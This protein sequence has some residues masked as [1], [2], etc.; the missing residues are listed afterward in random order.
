MPTQQ[1]T[2]Q[3]LLTSHCQACSRPPNVLV[4]VNL[5]CVLTL[6]RCTPACCLQTSSLQPALQLTLPT[7]CSGQRGF[8]A[9][10]CRCQTLQPN[11]S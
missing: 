4:R 3:Q 2:R 11:G 8:A 5:S 1:T 9:D 10:N 6:E 7:A